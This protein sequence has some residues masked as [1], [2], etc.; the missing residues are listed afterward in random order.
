MSQFLGHTST[1]SGTGVTH[2]PLCTWRPYEQVRHTRK[3]LPCQCDMIAK[4]RED[5]RRERVMLK[6]ALDY[7]KAPVT[8]AMRQGWHEGVSDCIAALRALQEKP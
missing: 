8:Q 3:F 1:E 2:D 7:Y 5:E 4:V 6:E